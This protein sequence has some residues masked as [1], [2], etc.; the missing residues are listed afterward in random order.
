M[1]FIVLCWAVL[2]AQHDFVFPHGK[3]GEGRDGTAPPRP[4][5]K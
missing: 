3:P 5:P 4:A 1:T 2:P